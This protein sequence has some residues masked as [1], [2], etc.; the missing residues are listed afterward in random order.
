MSEPMLYRQ[1]KQLPDRDSWHKACKE[2]IKA[3]KL[4]GIWEVVKLPSRKHAIGFRWFLKVKYNAN[5]PFC[6]CFKKYVILSL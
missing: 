4:N 6:F 2:E 5:G 3:Y 1:S